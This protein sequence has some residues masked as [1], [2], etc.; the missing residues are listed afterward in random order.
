MNE[1][2]FCKLPK[3]TVS[4]SRRRMAVEV[5]LPIKPGDLSECTNRCEL[6]IEKVLKFAQN[7]VHTLYNKRIIRRMSIKRLL[8]YYWRM[9]F[10]ITIGLYKK[11]SKGYRKMREWHL[12]NSLQKDKNINSCEV[13]IEWSECD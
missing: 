1:W 5:L 6:I 4:N 10:D 9:Q 3:K 8:S 13:N 2:I 7:R 11:E 12:S